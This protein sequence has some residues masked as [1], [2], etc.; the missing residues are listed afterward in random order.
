MAGGLSAMKVHP[1]V[2]WYGLPCLLLTAVVLWLAV[3]HG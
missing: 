1:V 3:A 2:Y